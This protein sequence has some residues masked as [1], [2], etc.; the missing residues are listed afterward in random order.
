MSAPAL[1][2]PQHSTSELAV[3]VVT[4]RDVADRVV[5]LTLAAPDRADLPAWTPGAHLELHLPN[6]L[7]RQYSLC[8]DPS[9]R[10]VYRVG[11][12][13]EVDGRGGSE[14]IHS[15]LTMGHSLTVGTPANHFEFVPAERHLFVAGGIGITP[16]MPMM[17]VAHDSGAP[18]SLVYLGRSRSTMAFVDEL[19]TRFP[20]H[21]DVRPDDECG[22][23]D[24]EA[25]V[26]TVLPGTQVHG[27]G[28]EGMLR[29][30]ETAM[31][32]WPAGSLRTERFA[33]KD[34]AALTAST[35]ACNVYFTESD[36]EIEVGADTTIVEAAEQAGVPVIYSCMEGTCGT[37]ETRVVCGEIDHRDSILSDEEK[38]ANDV[39]M[40][41]V[42]R[43]K[44]DRLELEL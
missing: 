18:W 43:A 40:I 21:I 20:G 31:A 44:G 23:T 5:E 11:I 2:R 12:L 6:G 13:R 41:C 1:D 10:T 3:E 26:S 16:L 9:D 7:R 17:Q 15:S 39:M 42:S 24:L 25:L 33:P 38:N 19:L 30:L 35:G 32:A 29:A 37:C 34:A 36:I 27:C 4:R 22:I 14:Y 28:P 8:G